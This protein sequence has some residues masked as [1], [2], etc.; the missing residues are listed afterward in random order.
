MIPVYQPLDIYVMSNKVQ[1]YAP[2]AF[3]LYPRMHDVWL[4][5]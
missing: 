2:N 3:T 1:G 5:Q 4:A